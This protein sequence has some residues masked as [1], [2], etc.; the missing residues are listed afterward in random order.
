MK[1]APLIAKYAALVLMALFCSAGC[2]TPKQQV[3]ANPKLALNP[4]NSRAPF[5]PAE[6]E[7]TVCLASHQHQEETS[8]QL[9]PLEQRDP[10]NFIA[11][12]PQSNE[13]LPDLEAFAVASNPTLRRMKHEAGAAWAKTGYVSKLPDPT[14]ST[15]FFTP[16]MNFEPDRQ[17]AD[18]QVMQMIPWLGR[19]KAEA[20]RAH[21]EALVAETQYQAEKLRVIGDI[22][23]TWMKLYVLRKQIETTETDQLQLESLITTANARVRTGDAQPGDVLMATLE[24][25]SLQEQLLG[26][27]QQIASTAA[28]LNR[29][30]GRDANMPVAPP[31][32]ISVEI[33]EWNHDLLRQ[34]AMENQP[35]LNAARLRTAATRWGIEIARLNQRPDLTF[36]VGWIVMDAPGAMMPNAGRDSLTLGVS[37]NIP[38]SHSKYEAMISESSREHYAAHASED[39][40]VLR[41]DALLRDLWEQASAS[42]KTVELY[43][44]SILPQARQTFETDQKSLIN[45]TVTFDRVIRDY[46]TLL[47]LELGYHRALGQLATTLARIRQ[48]AGVDLVASPE[49]NKTIN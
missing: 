39:E 48:A 6:A 44:T 45:N 10:E 17:L 8:R 11:P 9:Q 18:L 34:I 19:L 21:M 43:E 16:P 31:A 47:S 20:Q 36:G 4:I 42:R 29:L 25:S 23:A 12:H 24:L 49:L 32:K 38:V 3:R 2:E 22:R 41:L 26:Y 5:V 37:G 46:R 30:V 27:R 40:I 14:V 35:E 33:P 1:Q 15:M 7:S 13:T 28:E